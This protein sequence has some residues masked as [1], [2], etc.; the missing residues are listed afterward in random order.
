MRALILGNG[1][2]LVT[3]DATGEVRDLYFPHAGLENHTGGDT[4]HRI[5]VYCDGAL[6]WLSEDPRWEI[7][8]SCEE[9]SLESRITAKN[10][11]I[12]VELAFRDIVYNESSIFL[13]Q[14][15]V[16]NRA[17]RAREIKLYLGHK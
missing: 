16:T 12:E 13:R 15:T 5:G 14:I 7:Q 9:D 11:A 3:L 10:P 2:L 17:A 4:R 1:S 8:V 6:S